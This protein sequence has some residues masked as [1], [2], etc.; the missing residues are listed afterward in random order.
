MNALLP[1]SLIG[2]S[3]MSWGVRCM[4]ELGPNMP[5]S[6]K[7]EEEEGVRGLAVPTA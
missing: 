5:A 1:G 2:A 3:D 4:H 6:L 7:A